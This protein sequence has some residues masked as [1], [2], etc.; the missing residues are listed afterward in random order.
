MQNRWYGDVCDLVKWGTTIHL[1][2]DDP[3]VKIL[4][5]AMMRPD[6]ERDFS[7]REIGMAIA[8]TPPEKVL[9]HLGRFRLVRD[10]V[11][12]DKRIAIYD[13]PFPGTDQDGCEQTR[14]GYFRNVCRWIKRFQERRRVVLIDP[15]TGMKAKRCTPKHL[16]P[17][18]LELL[19][20]NLRTGDT[21]VLYQHGHRQGDWI[22]ATLALFPKDGRVRVFQCPEL[23][24]T[25]AL[26]AVRKS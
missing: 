24:S 23:T 3:K 13:K 9:T 5:V 11:H 18:E 25:V 20:K 6:D 7:L 26:F 22:G 2:G 8:H 16:Q 12:L 19:Y 15:D 17:V 1:A 4:Y 14:E 21:L 10:I